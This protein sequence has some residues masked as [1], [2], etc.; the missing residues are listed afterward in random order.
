MQRLL[1]VGVGKHHSLFR[2]PIDIGCL[3]TH[4]T[5]RITTQIRYADVVTP[6]HENVRLI[7]FLLCHVVLLSVL[8]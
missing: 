4:Q 7:L 5:V 6:D 1:A 2:E 8:S 3:I